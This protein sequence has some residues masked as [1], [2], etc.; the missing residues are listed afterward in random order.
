MLL[1]LSLQAP[2]LEGPDLDLTV[3][4]YKQHILDAIVRSPPHLYCGTV[5]AR[6]LVSLLVQR[7]NFLPECY[8]LQTSWESA[9]VIL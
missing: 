8:L 6:G 1:L 3:P 5:H 7:S 9:T 4:G 2:E